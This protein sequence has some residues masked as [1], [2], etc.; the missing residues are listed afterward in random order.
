VRLFLTKTIW[1]ALKFKDLESSASHYDFKLSSINCLMKF[2]HY[3]TIEKR[4]KI[5]V[6]GRMRQAIV[7]TKSPL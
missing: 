7:L 4:R 5:V 2:E 3:T 1:V 6:N